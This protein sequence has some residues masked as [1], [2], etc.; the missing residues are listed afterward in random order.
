MKR[1]IRFYLALFV[2][3][4]TYRV[5]KLL[6]RQGT[7]VPGLLAYYICPDFLGRMPR[8]DMVV[9]ITG[10]NG[11]TTV[12]NMVEDVLDECGYPYT[13]NRE[14][15]NVKTGLISALIANSS[16]LGKPRHALA[17]FEM[18]ERS[19]PILLPYIKP[20]LLLCTNI[21][22]DSYKRNA[23]PEYILSLLEKSIPDATELLL[24]GDDLLCSSLKENNKRSFFGI[25]MQPGEDNRMKNIACDIR[26]CPHCGETLE[27]DFIRYHHIG[28]AHCPRCGYAN[29][30]PDFVITGLDH[31]N[32]RF[33]LAH[34]GQTYDFPII[35]D[36]FIN[37]YNSL[38][39]AALLM[40]MGLAPERIAESMQKMKISESRYAE[41][42][43]GGKNIIMHLAKGQNP[44]ACSR[45]FEN[46]KDY[47]GTKSVFLYIDDI[48]DAA[49]S[50]EN[51]SWFY[52]TD[53]EFL[54][55]DSI[56]EILISGARHHD[57][58]VRLLLAGVPEEKMMHCRE[59]E[60]AIEKLRP[61][62][63]ETVFIIY[64]LYNIEIAGRVEKR[65]EEIILA[66]KQEE[67]A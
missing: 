15:S 13:C 36:T 65:A 46:A 61:E 21:F 19:A 57:V 50:V 6:G 64:D 16:A 22:R 34:D 1:N 26:N 10:T 53:F 41:K 5:M 2:A 58:F 40:R 54:N 43:V 67:Q 35:N 25:P 17:V 20:D 59:P 28:Q 12:S 49:N 32:R 38:A 27:W 47:P 60:E 3:K 48:H 8:P 44:I 37:I 55:D 30:A 4:I 39:A 42:T 11:K 66:D 7:T 52:D 51:I 29:P 33:T 45:A 14:G 63:A 31:E 56:A 18:D 23:H 24:N 9:G 62:K